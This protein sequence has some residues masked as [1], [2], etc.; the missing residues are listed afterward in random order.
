MQ[1]MSNYRAGLNRR[2]WQYQETNFPAWGGIFEEPKGDGKR[3]PVFDGGGWSN[4][5]IDPAAT[6][7]EK[8]RVQTMLPYGTRHR[9]FGS[10]TSSQ[11]LAQSVFANLFEYGYLERLAQIQSDE[12]L[13]ILVLAE[14]P[15]PPY[16][17]SMETGVR[18]LRERRPTRLDVCISGK[19]VNAIECK[20]TEAAFDICSRPRAK[21][22]GVPVCDGSYPLDDDRKEK[23]RLARAGGLYWHYIP[24]LFKWDGVG[25]LDACPLTKFDQLVRNV[26][27]AGIKPDRTV[28]TTG[29]HALLIYDNRNPAFQEGGA[30]F[31]AY[32]ETRCALREP[33]MLR[34]CSWQAITQYMRDEGILPWLTDALRGKYG[35]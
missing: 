12:G 3:P 7:D 35:L 34:K 29:G 17:F 28:S 23:C 16:R 13:P 31:L 32:E 10:M 18:Y 1:S 8:D 2:F 5:L 27:A 19:Y 6:P 11:A 9:W 22:N 21:R 25:D 15:I 26:L 33:A 24:M 4:I 20:F 14:D 30:A